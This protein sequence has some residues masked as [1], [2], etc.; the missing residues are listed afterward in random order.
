MHYPID[1][2]D[3]LANVL[4]YL[5][6][7]YFGALTLQG[8]CRAVRVA[9][10]AV[11]GSLLSLAVE[12]T[13]TF[14][15]TR[16]S[17]VWDLA[18]NSAGSLLGAVAAD[19][20]AIASVFPAVM[21]MCWAGFRVV[22]RYVPPAMD[23]ESFPLQ[24]AHYALAWLSLP[25]LIEPLTS[26]RWRR[27][28][29]LIL[30]AALM[31]ELFLFGH[32][33]PWAEVCGGALALAAWV[34]YLWRAEGRFWTAAAAI[35]LYIAIDALRPFEFLAH[36]RHFG[37]IPFL[38]I[39]QTVRQALISSIFVKVFMYGTLVWTVHRAGWKIS[40]TTL[41][42]TA[43]IL[44]SR[45]IQVFLPGRSAEITD[46]LMALLLGGCLVLLG[47]GPAESALRKGHETI[48]DPAH[49]QQVAGPGRI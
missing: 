47:P 8:R 42:S 37:M 43:F 34:L 33:R 3:S 39:I 28:T 17:N 45:L 21:V 2:F 40:K 5:P 19:V 4:L 32:Q 15:A 30:F 20:F 46:P 14:A 10:P 16:R 1:V 11:L 44:A 9:L 13:Q 31:G 38:S 49:G 41:A 22:S 25:V 48:T 12:L 18:A 24:A 6:I 23:S 26:P 29:P 7:G 36:P 27:I 35:V